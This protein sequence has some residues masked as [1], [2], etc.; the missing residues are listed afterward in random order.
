MRLKF[1]NEILFIPAKSR[2]EKIGYVLDEG[3]FEI[4][5]DNNSYIDEKCLI[6]LDE[7]KIMWSVYV[8]N[9]LHNNVQKLFQNST[10]RSNFGRNNIFNITPIVDKTEIIH[11]AFYHAHR[12]LDLNLKEQIEIKKQKMPQ[13]ENI[14]VFLNNILLTDGKIENE[15]GINGGVIFADAKNDTFEWTQNKLKQL[16]VKNNHIYFSKERIEMYRNQNINYEHE[17]IVNIFENIR[18]YFF[19]KITQD[20][21]WNASVSDIPFFNLEK[22]EYQIFEKLFNSTYNYLG[23]RVLS[24]PFEKILDNSSTCKGCYE[25]N[26]IDDLDY[27]VFMRSKT[28]EYNQCINNLIEFK[29]L[30]KKNKIQGFSNFNAIFNSLEAVQKERGLKS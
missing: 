4:P 2:K 7:F 11:Q 23:K 10:M 18:R 28:D 1:V 19:S 14:F 29:D 25:R 6:S 3:D 12:D 22:K 16:Y 21:I 17:S 5:N 13:Y 15:K 9:L 8:E 26:L 27:V 24:N 20:R 30:V